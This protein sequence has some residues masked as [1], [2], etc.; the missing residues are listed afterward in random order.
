MHRESRESDA[1][2]QRAR[3]GLGGEVAQES[4]SREFVAYHKRQKTTMNTT[5]A[6]NRTPQYLC[7]N[8]YE[9]FY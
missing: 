8:R 1:S 6:C 3:G 2:G 9:S 4:S 5:A 7:G